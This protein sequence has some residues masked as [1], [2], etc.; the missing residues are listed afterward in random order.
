M[1]D[2]DDEVLLF[3]SPED[4]VLIENIFKDDAVKQ[5]MLSKQHK[6]RMKKV[7]KEALSKYTTAIKQLELNKNQMSVIP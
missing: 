7:L 4:M 6:K 1:K 5:Q 2:L 3:F